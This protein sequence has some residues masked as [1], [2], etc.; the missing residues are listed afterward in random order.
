MRNPGTNPQYFDETKLRAAKTDFGISTTELYPHFGR[1]NKNY[2]DNTP[3]GKIADYVMA[4]N[5][6][7]PGVKPIWVDRKLL[8]DGGA[9]DQKALKLFEGKDIPL[10]FSVDTD[11]TWPKPGSLIWRLNQPPAN[12]PTSDI[13]KIW[14]D[15]AE[16]PVNIY[17]AADKTE[18]IKRIKFAKELAKRALDTAENKALLE[19]HGV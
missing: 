12:L 4:S 19:K 5:A 14:T 18:F 17:D 2:R 1:L 15:P 13:I 11:Q 16:Y 9:R 8:I 3:E 7:P 6:P 10:I